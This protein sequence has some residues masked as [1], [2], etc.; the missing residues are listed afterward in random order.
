MW[1]AY[2]LLSEQ[3]TTLH[4]SPTYDNLKADAPYPASVPVDPERLVSLQTLF[5]VHRDFYQGTQFDL[6][7]GMAAGPYGNPNR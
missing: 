3:Y 6:T 2:G 4:L 5:G 1:R 7:K